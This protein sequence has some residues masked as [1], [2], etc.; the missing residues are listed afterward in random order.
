METVCFGNGWGWKS[1]AAGTDRDG[2]LVLR[3]WMG[4]DTVCVV[5]DGDELI[6]H[7]RAALYCGFF[8]LSFSANPHIHLNTLILFLSNLAFIA[9]NQAASYT[10]CIYIALGGQHHRHYLTGSLLLQVH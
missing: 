7:C 1:S 4:M 9:I 3:G 5:T 10:T 6:F 2:K 8:I